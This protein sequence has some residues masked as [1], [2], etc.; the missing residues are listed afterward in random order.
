MADAAPSK[1][2]H[3]VHRYRSVAEGMAMAQA[4]L[5]SGLTMSEFA[6]QHDVTLRMVKYWSTRARHLVAASDAALA[7]PSAPP[8]LEHV[9][10]VDGGGAITITKTSASPRA[11]ADES[12]GRI[13]IRLARGVRIVVTPGFSAGLLRQVVVALEGDGAC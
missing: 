8:L 5:R 13:E 2:P 9:A 12:V 11:S 10:E 6:R 3:G 1:H 7:Q 4:Y